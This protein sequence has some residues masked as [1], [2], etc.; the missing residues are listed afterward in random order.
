MGDAET[1]RDDCAVCNWVLVVGAVLAAFT[2]GYMLVD[3][4]TDGKLSAGISGTL[5]GK[6][7]TV[8]DIARDAGTDDA[9]G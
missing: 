4:L 9:A 1:V 7:A 2:V 5:G 8:T 6:L 3:L